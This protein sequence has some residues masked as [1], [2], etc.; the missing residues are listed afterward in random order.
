MR[1]VWIFGIAA[2][3]ACACAAPAFAAASFIP[4]PI[5]AGGGGGVGGTGTGD[6]TTPPI[7]VLGGSYTFSND[8]GGGNNSFII[9][10]SGSYSSI[11]SPF[12][13]TLNGIAGVGNKFVIPTDTYFTVGN[14][15]LD[16]TAQDSYSNISHATASVTFVPGASNLVSG[17]PEPATWALMLFGF[18]GIGIAMR[19]KRA[20]L[21]AHIV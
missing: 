16:F 3:C 12:T 11:N 17:V 18:G 8:L 2:A 1:N 10:A 7:I 19:R 5:L 20:P 4:E 9:D 15:T 13:I 21:L 6:T 14:I